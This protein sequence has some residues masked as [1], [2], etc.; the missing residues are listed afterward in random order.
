[1]SNDLGLGKLITTPHGRDAIH[2]AVAPVVAGCDLQR[3][4]HVGL[5]GDGKACNL[6]T[7]SIGVVDPFLLCDVEFG[8]IF[9]LFLYPDTVTGM[10]HHWKH[11]VFDALDQAK[12]VAKSKQWLEEYARR[13]GNAYDDLMLAALSEITPADQDTV[14]YDLNNPLYDVPKEFW[15][16]YQVVTGTVVKAEDQTES[17][18][19][20]C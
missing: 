5:T 20:R 8:E 14:F 4:A 6:A 11:P 17:F 16:H 18:S 10:R 15:T 1:M 19:C 7:P 3:G 13:T 9:W 2:V 12:A